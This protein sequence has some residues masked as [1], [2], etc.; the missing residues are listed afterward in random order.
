MQRLASDHHLDDQA[1]LSALA[2]DATSEASVHLET[3]AA[4]RQELTRF[5]AALVA[6]REAVG[7]AADLAESRLGAGR[8]A[9]RARWNDELGRQRRARALAWT[10]AAGAALLSVGIGSQLW[11]AE[12]NP[13]AHEIRPTPVATATLASAATFAA[14]DADLLRRAEA[15]VEGRT[16]AALA[17]VEAL[18]DE[19]GSAASREGG[20]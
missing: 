5:R 13:H 3:C 11:Q 12:R 8:Q 10:A 16:P 1:F 14:S 4:C 19:L 2:D 20:V 6:H 15:A 18:L 7:F 17:P 9:V